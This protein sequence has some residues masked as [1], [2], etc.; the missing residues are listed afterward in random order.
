[1]IS[2][3]VSNIPLLNFK[4]VVQFDYACKV[5]IFSECYCANIKRDEFF[6]DRS[7]NSASE[8]ECYSQWQYG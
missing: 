8:S 6:V 4:C 3:A 1:M 5:L 7:F 2:T